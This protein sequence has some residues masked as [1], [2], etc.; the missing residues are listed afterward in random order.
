MNALNE[1]NEANWCGWNKVRGMTA[2]NL[3]KILKDFDIVSKSLR[4]NFDNAKG[5]CKEQ[6]INAFKRYLN[7]SAT[8]QTPL[9]KS[10][11]LTNVIP[12]QPKVYNDLSHKNKRHNDPSVTDQKT[13]KSCYSKVCNVVTDNTPPYR[14]GVDSH[15]LKQQ[16]PFSHQN[17]NQIQ[18]QSHQ[19]QENPMNLQIIP[20]EAVNKTQMINDLTKETVFNQQNYHDPSIQQN[21][22]D[23]NHQIPDL[24][25]L[26]SEQQRW[27]EHLAEQLTTT[28]AYLLEN[29]IIVVE[30]IVE[31]YNKYPAIIAECL[32]SSMV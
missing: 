20:K 25:S 19:Q 31:F 8:E 11:S 13:L 14:T 28:P 15:N 2:R 6:F 5:Y 24:S 3:A 16:T 27:L 21:V 32:K 22:D 23:K 10:A 1:D 26:T 12:S 30:D 9:T 17:Q 29:E 4:I 7:H 18:N